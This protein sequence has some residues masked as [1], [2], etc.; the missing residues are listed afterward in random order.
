MRKVTPGG[1]K[2]SPR[3]KV[4]K[5]PLLFDQFSDSEMLRRTLGSKLEASGT[6]VMIFKIFSPKN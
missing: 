4:K 3:G 1:S 6:D 5:R 2:F